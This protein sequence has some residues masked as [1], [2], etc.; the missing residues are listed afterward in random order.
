MAY[1]ESDMFSFEKAV[2]KMYDFYK[3]AARFRGW[4]K[5]QTW[6]WSVFSFESQHASLTEKKIRFGL[7]AVAR[8]DITEFL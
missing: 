1:W 2:E 8:A 6:G 5:F 4:H 7:F 3:E